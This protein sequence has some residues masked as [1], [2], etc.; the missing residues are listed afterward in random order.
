MARRSPLAGKK[1]LIVDDE[2]DVLE[3]LEEGLGMCELTKASNFEQAKKLLRTQ[4]FDFAIMDIMGVN[5][6]ELLEIAN[7]KKVTAIMLTAHALSPEDAVKSHREGAAS[8]VPKAKINDIEAVLNEI[9]EAK[10][11]GKNSWWRWHARF[12]SYFEKKFASERDNR[13]EFLK[14]NHVIRWEKYFH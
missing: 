2:I 9:L 3:T 6:Y 1:I 12:G 8:Y 13:L 5:G 4:H 11:E 14:E 10:E 7:Q